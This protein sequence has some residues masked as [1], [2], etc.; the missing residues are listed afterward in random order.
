M[1]NY[2]L[3]EVEQWGRIFAGNVLMVKEKILFLQACFLNAS[4]VQNV[5]YLSFF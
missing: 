3:K 1:D 5:M 4:N 2:T